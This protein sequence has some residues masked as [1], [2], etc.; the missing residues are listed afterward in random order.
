VPEVQEIIYA[1]Y[2]I[3]DILSRFE[4]DDS[5]SIPDIPVRN[6]NI[7]WT[8]INYGVTRLIMLG[9][10]PDDL[11][12]FDIHYHKRGELFTVFRKIV[13]PIN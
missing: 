5:G 3:K 1:E 11:R 8:L 6:F 7:W 12:C 13:E 10:R 2:R 4:R 9:S